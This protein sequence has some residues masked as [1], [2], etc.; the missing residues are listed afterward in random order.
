MGKKYRGAIVLQVN[1]F[2]DQ[3][4]NQYGF[5]FRFNLIENIVSSYCIFLTQNN[6][7]VAQLTSNGRRVGVPLSKIGN[8]N[9]FVNSIMKQLGLRFH[10]P[11]KRHIVNGLGMP[12]LFEHTINGNRCYNNNSFWAWEDKRKIAGHTQL[13]HDCSIFEMLKASSRLLEKNTGAYFFE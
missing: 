10:K 8:L 7:I 3:Y 6:R 11:N 5:I 12:M 1:G 4:N 13:R 2:A 9:G